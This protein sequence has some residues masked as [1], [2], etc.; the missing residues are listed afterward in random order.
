MKYKTA[1]KCDR[2]VIVYLLIGVAPVGFTAILPAAEQ[3]EKVENGFRWR[4]MR[5]WNADKE[6]SGSRRDEMKW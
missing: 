6:S 2:L 3:R 1:S 4:Q 5:N